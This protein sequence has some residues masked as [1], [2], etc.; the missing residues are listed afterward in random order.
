MAARVASPRGRIERVWRFALVVIAACGRY[1]FSARSD[2]GASDGPDARDP[3]AG[4]DLCDQFE[5]PSLRSVWMASSGVTLDTTHAHSGTQSVHL[6]TTQIAPG[7]TMYIQLGENQTLATAVNPL[8]VRGWFWMPAFPAAGNHSELISVE[9]M[10]GGL[11]DYLFLYSTATVV[12]S[13]FAMATGN[14]PALGSPGAWFCAVFEVSRAIDA[15]GKLTLSSDIVG[16]QGLTNVVT[17]SQA[18]PIRTIWLGIGF[19]GGNVTANQPALDLWIDDVIVHSA[20]VTC[21]D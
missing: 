14:T 10:G 2:A 1:D 5:E 12:Y 21:A 13:Q 20:P 7:Q 8:W 19:A 11:G 4:F 16:P 3:C 18:T 17:D 15:T 9:Q 6:H